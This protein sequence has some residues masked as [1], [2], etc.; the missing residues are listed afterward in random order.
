MYCTV[1]FKVDG[2]LK[3]DPWCW[4]GDGEVES[5]ED[6]VKSFYTGYRAALSRIWRCPVES[7]IK[8]EVRPNTLFSI[9][10]TMDDQTVPEEEALKA[11]FQERLRI[12]Q[13][14]RP[15]YVIPNHELKNL[16]LND[17]QE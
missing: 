6:A 17:K 8:M 3:A 13:E 10:M 11:F 4:K 16:D 12:Y 2:D 1:T 14:Q 5:I 9:F 7:D 15:Q